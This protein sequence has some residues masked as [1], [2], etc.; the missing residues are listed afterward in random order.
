MNKY[1]NCFK[2]YH[3]TNHYKFENIITDINILTN[4]VYTT[5]CNNVRNKYNIELKDYTFDD[6]EIYLNPYLQIIF[7]YTAASAKISVGVLIRRK[8]GSVVIRAT[9]VIDTEKATFNIIFMAM[10]RFSAAVSFAPYF[11]AVITANPAVNPVTKPSTR[12]FIGPVVPTAARAAVP[13]SLPT[14]IVS[15]MLY[16]CCTK[17][18]ISN[19]IE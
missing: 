11:C 12:K 1:K 17:L 2:F 9:T 8:I 3:L 5:A 14:I 16:N 7:I 10:E 19:G 13:N 4:Y 6:E 18:P 15:A